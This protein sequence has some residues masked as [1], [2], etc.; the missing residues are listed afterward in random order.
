MSARM[1]LINVKGNGN[2]M[3][4]TMLRKMFNISKKKNKLTI[5]FDK[6]AKTVVICRFMCYNNKHSIGA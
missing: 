4:F 3:N 1:I 2:R 5:V 6:I